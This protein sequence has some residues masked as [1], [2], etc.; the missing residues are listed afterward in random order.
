MEFLSLLHYINRK[1]VQIEI[2]SPTFNINRDSVCLLVQYMSI[3][4]HLKALILSR[5]VTQEHRAFYDSTFGGCVHF[6]L[7]YKSICMHIEFYL[8][9]SLNQIQS[10]EAL[11]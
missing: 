7:P 4:T 5:F 8:I 1:Y 10:L 9:N 6:L 2:V 3:H 11:L